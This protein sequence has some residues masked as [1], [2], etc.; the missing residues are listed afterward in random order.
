MKNGKSICRTCGR[1]LDPSCDE[2]GVA[3]S[4]AYCFFQCQNFKEHEKEVRGLKLANNRG[5]PDWQDIEGELKTKTNHG[6]T[7]RVCA[8]GTKG[9]PDA[10]VRKK[11]DLVLMKKKTFQIPA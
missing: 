2:Y 6:V 3:H 5:F 4:K 11:G 8:I 1:E 10:I 7:Y 9:N